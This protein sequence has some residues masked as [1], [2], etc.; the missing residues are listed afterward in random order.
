MKLWLNVQPP[1]VSLSV[2]EEED[3]MVTVFE[4]VMSNVI[5]EHFWYIWDTI[6]S[7]R[8]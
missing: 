5:E 1:S 7:N 6:R 2:T 8:Y 3:S 4:L